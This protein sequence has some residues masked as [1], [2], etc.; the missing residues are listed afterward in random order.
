MHAS[1]GGIATRVAI[2]RTKAKEPKA[3]PPVKTVEYGHDP[4][5]EMTNDTKARGTT[6][7]TA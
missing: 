6:V 5:H 1:L 2:R 7:T 4:N 3:H